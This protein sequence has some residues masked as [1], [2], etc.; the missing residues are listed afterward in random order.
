MFSDLFKC[1]FIVGLK[2]PFNMPIVQALTKTY[3]TSEVA[4]I[5]G[6]DKQTLLRWLWSG[7]V[8]EPKLYG[9]AQLNSVVGL[10]GMLIESGPTK[11]TT[12]AKAGVA[13]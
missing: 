6:I 7:K 10:V 13:K 11:K 8:P 1:L 12:I 5:V 4:R 3:S 9:V 2:C